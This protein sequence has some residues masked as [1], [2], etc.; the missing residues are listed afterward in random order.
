MVVLTE[1]NVAWSARSTEGWN[2]VKGI[3]GAKLENHLG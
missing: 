2:M 1:V 3:F